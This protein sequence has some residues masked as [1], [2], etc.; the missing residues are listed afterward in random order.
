MISAFLPSPAVAMASYLEGMC[1]EDIPCHKDFTRSKLGDV[2]AFLCNFLAAAVSR[3]SKFSGPLA[4]L[5]QTCMTL[6]LFKLCT[7]PLRLTCLQRLS[8]TPTLPPRILHM[9]LKR[10]LTLILVLDSFFFF[11]L[12]GACRVCFFL[13]L[14]VSV[15]PRLLTWRACTW[16]ARHSQPPLR[17]QTSAFYEI[18]KA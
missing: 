14:F 11:A 16:R 4:F 13:S 1:M 8:L 12:V 17:Y 6:S 7:R 5:P 18:S 2:S 15:L 3:L 10:R 9:I